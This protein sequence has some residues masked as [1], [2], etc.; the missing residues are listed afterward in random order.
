MENGK[1][2]TG[3]GTGLLGCAHRSLVDYTERATV[4]LQPDMCLTKLLE[5][6][7]LS[8]HFVTNFI[9][10]GYHSQFS[11]GLELDCQ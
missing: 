6:S 2:S 5:I 3:N 11:N 7:S 4:A 10:P 1:I 8:L 9:E